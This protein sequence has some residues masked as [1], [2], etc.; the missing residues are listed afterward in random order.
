MYEWDLNYIWLLPSFL[1][2][3]A[4][5]VITVLGWRSILIRFSKSIAFKQHVKIYSWTSLVQR[6]PAGILWTVAGRTYW[7]QKLDVP[8]STAATASFLEIAMAIFVGIPIGLLQLATLFSLSWI[9]YLLISIV[10][11]FLLSSLFLLPNIWRWFDQICKWDILQITPSRRRSLTWIGIYGLV[12]LLS[13]MILYL[14]IRLFYD[15]PVN[16]APQIIGIW[17][18]ASLMAYVTALAPSGLG[19]K[20]LSLTYL[21]KFYLP[22]PLP[23]V[24]AL[25]TRLLWTGYEIIFAAVLTLL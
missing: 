17:T 21:L 20:E 22:E 7:Y 19:V 24:V 12:W 1:L 16:K 2:F 13:G 6:I 5:N 25:V 3:V 10:F 14:V 11:L 23:L 8:A 15:L 9:V 4:Q 18:L